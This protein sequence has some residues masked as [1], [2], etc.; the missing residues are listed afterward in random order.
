LNEKEPLKKYKVTL[1]VDEAYSVIL[2]AKSPQEAEEMA[3][4]MMNDE[5]P[6]KHFKIEDGQGVIIEDTEEIK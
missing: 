3:L 5:D 2:D 1:S 4:N 6:Y